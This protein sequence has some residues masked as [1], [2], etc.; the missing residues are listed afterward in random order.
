MSFIAKKP[1]YKKSIKI[2]FLTICKLLFFFL[3]KY[4]KSILN[5]GVSSS[6]KQ[7]SCLNPVVLMKVD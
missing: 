5:L 7:G 2:N 4:K 1:C 3:P 6:T